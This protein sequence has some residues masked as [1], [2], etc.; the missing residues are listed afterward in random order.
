MILINIGDELLIGQVVNTNAAFVGRQ[1]SAAGFELTEVVTIGD[2]GDAIRAALGEAFRK[3]DTVIMTGGLGPTK[4]DITKK[5]VCDLF[6][7]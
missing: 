1:F 2:S 7:R 3:T 4:D 5:V 6:Q